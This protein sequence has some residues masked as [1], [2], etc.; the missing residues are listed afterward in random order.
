MKKRVLVLFFISIF[1]I[2]MI[3]ALEIKTQKD[4]FMKAETFQATLS[5]N[6]LQTIDKSQ[7][8]FYRG[9]VQVPITF[10]LTKISNI[11]YI[12][13]ELPFQTENYSLRIKDVYFKENQQIIKQDLQK[14][15]TVSNQTADFSINPGFIVSSNDFTLTLNN[16]ID[17]DISVSYSLGNTTNQTQSSINVPAQDSAQITIPISSFNSTS[18]SNLILSSGSQTYTIPVYIV[19]N[20]SNQGNIT[21]IDTTKEML[22]FPIQSI[23]MSLSPNF[24]L[25]SP[26]IEITNRGGIVSNNISL[27]V[28]DSLAQHIALNQTSFDSIKPGQVF[29]LIFSSQFNTSGNYSGYIRASSTNSSA[30]LYLKFIIQNNI[31][32]NT[33]IGSLQTCANLGGKIC[34]S[35]QICSQGYTPSSEGFSCCLSQCT[36]LTPASS[37]S[38]NWIWITVIIAVLAAIGFFFWLRSKKPSFKSDILKKKTDEFDERFETKGKLTKF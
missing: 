24:L 21:I 4:N 29:T 23:N 30:F 28:S 18:F 22:Y 17:S 31:L 11:Y 35:D 12:Y 19:K 27:S 37:S 8:G 25:N 9:N 26:P 13:A 38:I 3:S 10:D 16:N 1:L 36:N 32:T 7:V 5:G 34:T 2:S 20:P 6:I 14:N 33:S 15:F